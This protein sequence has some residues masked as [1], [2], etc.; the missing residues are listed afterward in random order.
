MIP[1]VDSGSNNK[2]A[3]KVSRAAF[4]THN[5]LYKL[6]T[7]RNHHAWHCSYDINAI[8]HCNV[9]MLTLTSSINQCLNEE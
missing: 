4:Y 6:H 2:K 7:K 3:R 1:A 8:N 9:N 5:T